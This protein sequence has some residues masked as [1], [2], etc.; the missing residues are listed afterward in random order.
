MRLDH[1]DN[2]QTFFF[3]SEGLKT[4]ISP[5]ET[6]YQMFD[7]SHNFSTLCMCKKVKNV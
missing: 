1:F 7:P 2:R 4:E 6:L 5:Q 3:N